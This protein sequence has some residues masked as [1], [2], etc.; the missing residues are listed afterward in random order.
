MLQN[1]LDHLAQV[2]RAYGLVL[3]YSAGGYAKLAFR[4]RL[5]AWLR[6][7]LHNHRWGMARYMREGRIELCPA[8]DLHRREFY[9]CGRGRWACAACIR[10]DTH[11]LGLWKLEKVS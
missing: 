7:Q 9:Y 10:L 2:V 4:Y 3:S 8:P 5:P 11:Q 1:D 6:R